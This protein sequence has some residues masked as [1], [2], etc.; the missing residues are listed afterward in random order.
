MNTA[1]FQAVYFQTSGVHASRRTTPVDGGSGMLV[2]DSWQ[3]QGMLY[4]LTLGGA[5]GALLRTGMA[6]A[7][8]VFHFVRGGNPTS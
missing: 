4:K 8:L 7:A 1:Y 5:G 6:G 2:Q 3:V